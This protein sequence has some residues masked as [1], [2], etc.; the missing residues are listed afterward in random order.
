MFFGSVKKCK[1]SKPP[2][3]PTPEFLTPPN[4]VLR[5]LTNQ[6]FTHT[7]PAS[8]SE[9]IRWALDAGHTVLARPYFVLFAN[10]KTSSSESK[11]VS[12]TTGPK[13]SSWLV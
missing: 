13:I 5:S 3:L 6:Q 8:N 1:A 11:G 4:G 10:F 9:A 12:V 7:I 2:S